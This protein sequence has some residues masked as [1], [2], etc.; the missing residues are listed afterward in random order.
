MI[1]KEYLVGIS[2]DADLARLVEV[3]A[4]CTV[5][6]TAM[7]RVDKGEKVSGQN[8]FGEQQ[9]VMDVAADRFVYEKLKASGLV[10]VVA[11]EEMEDEEKSKGGRFGVAHDPLD[12]SSLID[13]NLAVGSIFGVY[14]TSSF[15]GVSG[16]EQV[17]AIVACYGPRLGLFVTVG[18]G[19][20]YFIFDGESFV[21]QRDNL[22]IAEK[23]EMFAPGN[24]RACG[25]RE[26]YL[27]L[28]NFWIKEGYRLRYSGGMVPDIGQ[29][30]LKGGGVFTYPGF[31]IDPEG[32]L[33]IL[34][35]CAPMA[36][37]VE[38]AGGMASDGVMAILDKRID[39]LTSR[40]PIYIGSKREVEIVIRE[41][42]S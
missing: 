3:I 4:G 2:V 18:K 19:T 35:E 32:K 28:V 11:S 22:Q 37:L 24:L 14:E 5:E 40:T 15:Y 17:A 36:F 39:D 31:S 38:Q 7:V 13:V 23:A 1:L 34:Y 21:L 9:V 25:E 8:V 26:D 41:L 27:R 10:A 16:R 6:I 29:I 33:R 42:E 20:A 30:L 12:G